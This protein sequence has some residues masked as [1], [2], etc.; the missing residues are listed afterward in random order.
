M[1][2]KP[3]PRITPINAPFFEACNR[4]EFILQRCRSEACR[5]YIYFPR[6]CC[7]YCGGGELEWV[8]ASGKGRIKSFT[9]I[10]R[11]QHQSFAPEVPYCFAAVEL[12]EGPLMYSRIEGASDG[13]RNL[14]GAS[15]SVVFVQHTAEQKLPF[16]RLS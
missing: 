8:P 7:P 13:A 11:P 3:A 16:F 4:D 2:P 5:R 15:V 9:V 12:E 6:V 14:L 10:R 1:E